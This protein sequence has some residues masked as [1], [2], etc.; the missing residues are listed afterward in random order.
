MTETSQGDTKIMCYAASVGHTVWFSED[1]AE[2]WLRAFTPTG[3]MYNECRCWALS[4][5]PDRPDEVWAGTDQGLYKWQHSKGYWGYVPS[6]LDGLHI[7][8]MAQSPHD[9]DVLV[10]GTRPAELFISRDGGS[11]WEDANLPVDSECDFINTPRVTSIQFDPKEK[12]TLWVT[13]EIAGILVS[14]D[15]GRTWAHVTEGLRTP[16]VHN[17]VIVDELPE[18]VI[19]C[20]TELGLHRSDDGGQSFK[21]VP[22]PAAGS[23]EYFRCMMR[24]ADNSGVMFMSIGDRPSGNAGALLRS[25][26]YGE[27]WEQVDLPGRVS[28]T[29]WWIYTN[30]ADPNF[31]LCNS[32]FGEVFRS[33]DGGEN[34]DKLPKFLGELRE[35]AWQAVPTSLLTPG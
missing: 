28:T 7:L 22:V 8:K 15:A 13:V 17:I 27:T 16:D 10:V 34:W 21:H 3:G 14:H 9:A 5:H 19:Y 23:F 20:S 25:R 1:K 18:R 2:S 29:I 24:R 35:I 26:D 32:M 30:P 33:L 4:T 6:P 11:T 12:D 31:I